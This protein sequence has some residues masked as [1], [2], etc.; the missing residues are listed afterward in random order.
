[1]GISVPPSSAQFPSIRMRGWAAR[2]P[3]NVSVMIC[4]GNNNG[5]KKR[6]LPSTVK[7][8]FREFFFVVSS[9]GDYHLGVTH[10]YKQ[11]NNNHLINKLLNDISAILLPLDITLAFD[12]GAF[13]FPLRG[14]C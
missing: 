14:Q 8:T 13:V 10:F 1:M 5:G 12:G 4:D 9:I 6:P 11:S 7:S 3:R 2:W